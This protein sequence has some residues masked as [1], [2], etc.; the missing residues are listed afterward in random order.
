MSIKNKKGFTLIE[1]I[2]VLVILAIL[3]LIVTPLVMNIIRKARIS[4]DKRSI[5]AYGRSIEYAISLYLLDNL[6]YPTSIDRL[7]IEYSGNQ[8]VCSTTQLNN[9]SSIY[10]AGCTVNGRSVEGYTYGKE[11]ADPTY[12]AYQVGDEVTYNNINYYV[13]KDSDTTEES[14]TLLKEEPL[15]VAEVNQFGAGHINRYTSSSVGTAYDNNGYGGMAYYTSETCGYVNNTWVYTGCKTDYASSEIKYV[16]D[17][18]KAAKAPAADEARLLTYEETSEYA[19][20]KQI[21]TGSCYEAIG[22]K[23]DWMYNNNY[24]YWLGTPYTDS[25]SFVWGVSGN[26]ALG[27]DNVY[28][29]DF[30]GV[31]RPVITISKSVISNAGN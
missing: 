18:W 20:A 8:V 11:E 24:W 3:A 6:K 9:D 31:V 1:L 17:A 25:S 29:R 10:L 26:G 22:L 23:Y 15:S 14:V 7:T 5:D 13:I 2:A 30:H 27:S 19:E 16:V 28:S 4:A 21:C 12:T